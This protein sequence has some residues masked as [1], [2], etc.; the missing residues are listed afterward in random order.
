MRL[1]GTLDLSLGNFLCLRGF[2][3][4]GD[5]Y[6]LSEPAPSQRN[7]ID[8][9][10]DE[11]V[12]FLNQGE[13]LFVPEVILATTLNHGDE[14]NPA[15]DELFQKA[16]VGERFANLK[17]EDFGLSCSLSR[18]QKKEDKRSY[19]ILRTATLDLY[20][21]RK[22]KFWRIDGNH[23]LS[24]TP[25][26]PKFRK[27]NTPYCLLFFRNDIVAARFGRALFHNI[28]Y[29]Q[30]PLTMEQSLKLIVDEENRDLFPDDDLK[31]ISLLAGR[32]TLLANFITRSIM[33]YFRT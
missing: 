25:E 9:H 24:A 18:T 8:E 10:R 6:D 26:D 32:I 19:D 29:K 16:V 31:R 20:K 14:A 1:R 11:M 2:A 12:A 28:N 15:V 21:N 22:Y 5:L 3:P 13:F 4:M 30:V 17:F 7:L 27:H 23:R 33:T